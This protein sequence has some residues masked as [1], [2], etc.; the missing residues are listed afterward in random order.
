M[1]GPHGNDRALQFTRFVST[2]LY[3]AMAKSILSVK[4][5]GPQSAEV[6]TLTTSDSVEDYIPSMEVS[7][8]STS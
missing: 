3:L 7:M 1:I 2:V 4:D 5:P 6:G 8:N